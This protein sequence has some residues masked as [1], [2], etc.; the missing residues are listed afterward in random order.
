MWT[1]IVNQ[2]APV[3]M[4]V[5]Q[6]ADFVSQVQFTSWRPS[7][8]VLHNTAAPTLAQWH[9]VPGT[10]RIANLVSYFRD[11]RN[12]SAGPH[13]FVADDLIWPFTPFNRPGVHSPSWNGTK[14][15]I[16]MVGDFS[17]ENADQGPGLKVMQNTVALFGIL[18]ARLG[19]DPDTIKFHKEDPQTTHNCPGD[20]ILKPQFIRLVKE[21]MG[22]GGDHDKPAPIVSTP[23]SIPPLRVGTV[24]TDGLNVREHAGV[25]S[26]AM[27]S[28]AKG[29]LLNIIGSAK[30]GATEWLQISKPVAGWVAAYFV[31]Q[32]G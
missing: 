8:M 22:E 17:V 21:Y 27:Q 7:G 23:V 20:H 13:A 19:L 32:K 3:G 26:R 5:L 24:K 16:E 14:L 28:L 10:D 15:G 1:P 6:L 12:W 11:Q 9:S 18:H 25:S 30:N 31:E 2:A 29:T 4:T